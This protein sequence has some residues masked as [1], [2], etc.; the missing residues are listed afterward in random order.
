MNKNLIFEVYLLISDFLVE[1][2]KASKNQQ[3]SSLILQY[4]FAQKTFLVLQTS[5][6]S[7]L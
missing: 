5:T 4:S 1:S 3:K 7:T 6:H 2:L